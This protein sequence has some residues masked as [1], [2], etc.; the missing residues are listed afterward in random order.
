MKI[1]SNY[2]E[3]MSDN[4]ITVN[5]LKFD[6]KVHRSWKCKILKE[7]E[8]LILL[9]GK[10]EEE[11]RHSILGLI[12][13]GTISFEFFWFDRWF[14]V[15]RF[16]EPD[17]S[18]RNFYC[19]INLPPTFENNVLDYVDLDIDVLVWRDFSYQVLDIDEFERNAKKFSYS[20]ELRETVRRT[21]SE[22]ILKVENR[23]YPFDYKF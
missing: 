1:T 15:F 11:V 12:R 20:K 21:L 14:N 7:S 3:Q 18:F 4:D 6:G 2:A 17:G 16:H 19:N 8:N 5:S 13:R 10:F 23:V 9:E 22:L